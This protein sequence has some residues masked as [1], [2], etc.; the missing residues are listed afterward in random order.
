MTGS[1]TNFL[2]GEDLEIT[3]S[4][5]ESG[6][7]EESPENASMVTETPPEMQNEEYDAHLRTEC[8]KTH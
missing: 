2:I 5:I 7:F 1:N 4:L 8:F 6:S 3:L